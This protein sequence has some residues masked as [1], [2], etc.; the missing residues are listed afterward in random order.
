MGKKKYSKDQIDVFIEYNE[1]F[2]RLARLEGDA[3][4]GIERRVGSLLTDAERTEKLLNTS[5]LASSVGV[6]RPKMRRLIDKWE[7][8]GQVR[9]VKSGAA[10]CIVMTETRRNLAEESSA[11][12]V[13][14]ILECA[15]K[16]RELE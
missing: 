9:R 15:D 7:A 5:A 14:L 16:I 12:L 11:Q 3:E 10:V 6:S 1:R 4:V 8:D 2:Y 13:D